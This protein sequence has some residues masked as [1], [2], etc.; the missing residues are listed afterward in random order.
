MK[1][2]LETCGWVRTEAYNDVEKLAKIF[3][4]N[5]RCFLFIDLFNNKMFDECQIIMIYLSLTDSCAFKT[6]YRATAEQ[7]KFLLPKTTFANTAWHTYTSFTTFC[8]G[9]TITHMI[10]TCH[11][12][13]IDTNKNIL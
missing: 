10:A 3:V 2:C 4:S 6:I 9:I 5:Y 13:D 8:N 1:K 7:L 11:K 12:C